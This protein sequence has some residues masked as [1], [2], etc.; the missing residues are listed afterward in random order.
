ML[1]K[2][3][4][5]PCFKGKAHNCVVLARWLADACR[6]FH[7][8]GS[9]SLIRCNVMAAWVQFFAAASKSEDPDWYS[10]QELKRLDVSCKMLLHGSKAL[11]GANQAACKARW[12]MR[13]KIHLIH[14]VNKNAQR[15]ER[16]VRAFWSFKE[17]EGMG[18]L[19]AIASRT[20]GATV[21]KRSLQR[22]CVQF[23]NVSEQ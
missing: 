23:L 8:A 3:T 14:H 10:P 19:S 9:Y 22:W 20:H 7:T 6:E 17:E 12:E 21:A 13:P 18:K 1:K 11:A 15:S 16:V 5:W 4:S 2:S